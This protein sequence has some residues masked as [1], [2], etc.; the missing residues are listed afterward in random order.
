MR[1]DNGG[2]GDSG[3]SRGRGAV[4]FHL[5]RLASW[6]HRGWYLGLPV[7]LAGMLVDA[8]A[9][10]VWHSEAYLFEIYLSAS[11]LLVLCLTPLLDNMRRGHV[12]PFELDVGFSLVYF[13]YFGARA[14]WLL[15]DPSTLIGETPYPSVVLAG[16]PAAVWYADLGMA[17]Y[18]AGYRL[19]SHAQS[20]R[21]FAG[22]GALARF[23]TRVVGVLVLP[24]YALGF[25]ARMPDLA[26]G[27][28][29]GFAAAE[30]AGSVPAAVQS[31]TYF[32]VLGLLAYA[33]VFVCLA[34]PGAR[35]PMLWAL[36]S[37]IVPLEVMFAFITGSKFYLVTLLCIP[38][39]IGHYLRRRVSA[40]ALA[41]LL[42]VYV[43]AVAPAVS[44]YRST[45]DYRELRF[46]TMGRELPRV[47]AQVGTSLLRLSPGAY[48]ESSFGAFLHR[49][50]GVDGLAIVVRGVPSRIA[51]QRGRTLA[52]VGKVL[53]PTAVW[54]R[55]Y[56]RIEDDLSSVP[57]LFGYPGFVQGGIG[58]TEDAELYLNF[59]VLGI[60]AGMLGIGMLHRVGVIW[61]QCPMSPWRVWI[62]SLAW[63]WMMF[64]VEG[65]FYTIYPNV[66]RTVVLALLVVW[67]AAQLSRALARARHRVAGP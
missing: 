44:V 65:W 18:L 32:S 55:K 40:A 54:P 42:A 51:F 12:D 38:V 20:G 22:S 7:V 23:D 13:L 3:V 27:W 49:L 14:L 35:N 66:F 52:W 17:A 46:G 34:T 39:I 64:S 2:P 36:A 56:D 8:A 24:L 45:V 43:F 28:F 67:A 37:V 57:R 1:R 25:L 16:L 21:P 63:P 9:R 6:W 5:R 58:L 30:F 15:Y 19:L 53:V 50:S 29:M 4:C 11:I 61:L 48:V 31:L 62:Y 60:L 10:A 26:H 33:L 41:G 47:A 59:G